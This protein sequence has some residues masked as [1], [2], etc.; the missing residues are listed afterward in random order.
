[1]T[2]RQRYVYILF[3]FVEICKKKIPDG[4]KNYKILADDEL[5]MNSVISKNVKLNNLK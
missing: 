5:K 3:F 1:M 2:G 4:W